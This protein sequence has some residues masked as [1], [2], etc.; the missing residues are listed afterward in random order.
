MKIEFIKYVP[1]GFV[2]VWESAGWV[3][4]PILNDTHHAQ[5]AAALTPGPNCRW[6]GG[7]PVCPQVE[8]AA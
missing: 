6:E 1:L 3:V 2:H 7:D 8:D 4:T 5:Y